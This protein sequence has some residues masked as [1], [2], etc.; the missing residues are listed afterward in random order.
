MSL[1][2]R[3]AVPRNRKHG[4][5]RMA[6]GC[7]LRVQTCWPFAE[8]LVQGSQGFGGIPLGEGLPKFLIVIDFEVGEGLGGIL[9]RKK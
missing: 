3:A 7:V 9:K 5:G 6:T 1:L 2:K 4:L 8:A